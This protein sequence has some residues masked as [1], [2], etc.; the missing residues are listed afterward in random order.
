MIGRRKARKDPVTPEVREEV[1]RRDRRCFLS[2]IE[3]SHQC[4][5][6]W[7]T[8]HSPFDLDRCT[9]D[10]VKREARMGRRAPSD[11]AHLL[12]M[13]AS[14][15]VGVPSKAVREAERS[16]LAELYPEAWA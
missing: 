2:R 6:A 8:P 5:D 14:A 10:H 11:P 7:G 13:C 9:L 4:R 16:Y 3:P 15:N 12:A 1:L